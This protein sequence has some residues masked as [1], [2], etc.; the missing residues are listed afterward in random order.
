MEERKPYLEWLP[1]ELKRWRDMEGGCI[2]VSYLELEIA[3]CKETDNIVMDY[4]QFCKKAHI[5]IFFEGM[6]SSSSSNR[7]SSS[8]DSSSDS[9][10]ASNDSDYNRNASDRAWDSMGSNGTPFSNPFSNPYS[11]GF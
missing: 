5:G 9:S 11:S 10:S 4:N 2:A 7:R 3:N 6:H 8:S 1:L